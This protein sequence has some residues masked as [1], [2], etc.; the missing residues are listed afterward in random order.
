[1]VAAADFSSDREFERERVQ[2][3]QAKQEL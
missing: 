3:T 1:M 2:K